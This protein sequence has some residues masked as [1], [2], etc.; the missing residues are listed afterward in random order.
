M[1]NNLVRHLRMSHNSPLN[2]MTG[3]FRSSTLSNNQPRPNNSS[4]SGPGPSSEGQDKNMVISLNPFELQGVSQ[5]EDD[6]HPEGNQQKLSKK[7]PTNGDHEDGE[8]EGNWETINESKDPDEDGQDDGGDAGD[9][10]KNFECDHCGKNFKTSKSLN[11]H[12]WYLSREKLFTCPICNRGFKYSTDLNRHIST[13]GSEGV[14]NT[15]LQQEMQMKRTFLE[16]VRNRPF[17]R[18][19]FSQMP[20]NS[21]GRRININAIASRPFACKI[22]PQRFNH[23]SNLSRHVRMIHNGNS[24][25]NTTVRRVPGSTNL[26]SYS[27]KLSPQKHYPTQLNQMQPRTRPR[28]LLSSTTQN[29]QSHQAGDEQWQAW[30]G[31]DLSSE[32]MTLGDVEDGVTDRAAAI[33]EAQRP[34]R[35]FVEQSFPEDSYTVDPN[36]PRPYICNSCGKAFENKGSLWTHMRIH[37]KTFSCSFCGLKTATHGDLVLHLRTH[38]GESE[39]HSLFTVTIFLHY[40]KSIP[41]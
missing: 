39:C 19:Q 24:G 3:A 32:D 28:A 29:A 4:H 10:D 13:H 34:P 5:D 35:G 17:K 25:S 23:R 15:P 26:Q 38:T 21:A 31:M 41:R 2:K 40:S 18:Q 11:T 36:S 14:R 1:K 37:N 20:V 7:E 30:S 6:D 16:S 33:A 8:G 12:K 22:C 9:G 27:S